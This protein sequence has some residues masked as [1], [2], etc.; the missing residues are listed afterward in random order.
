MAENNSPAPHNVAYFTDR[1]FG[2]MEADI[3]ALKEDIKENKKKIGEL[4][5]WKDKV[6]G[7]AWAVAML[8]AVITVVAPLVISLWYKT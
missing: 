2:N 8:W 7:A 1:D 4:Q 5:S 6:L 3:K